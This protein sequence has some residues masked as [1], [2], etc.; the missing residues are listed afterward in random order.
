MWTSPRFA[1][2]VPKIGKGSFSPPRVRPASY[3]W[4]GRSNITPGVRPFALPH[5]NAAGVILCTTG[6]QPLVLYIRNII[7]DDMGI[8]SPAVLA[9]RG[10]AMLNFALTEVSEVRYMRSWWEPVLSRV[11]AT[12]SR[13]KDTGYQ[14][15]RLGRWSAAARPERA[16]PSTLGCPKASPQKTSGGSS[17]ATRHGSGWGFLT[18][19]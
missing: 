4:P 2:S 15:S 1:Y 12:W 17:E 18:Q 3:L 7:P 6:P 8:P 19:L 9:Y 10:G 13:N 11:A 14:A 16:A 5:P